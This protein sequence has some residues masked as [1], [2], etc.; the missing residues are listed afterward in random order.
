MKTCYI[1]SF[2]FGDRRRYPKIYNSDRLIFLKKQIEYLNNIENNLDTIIFNF[3]LIENHY[4][5]FNQAIKL[6]PDYINNTK[7]LINIRKNHDFSYG[8]WNEIVKKEVENY[9]HFIFGE[10][11]YVFNIDRWDEYL[12][13]KYESL[14]DC[15]YLGMGVRNVLTKNRERLIEYK[16]YSELKE[17]FH[18][19]GMVSS[20]NI[21]KILKIKENL[22]EIKKLNKYE[23]EVNGD[24]IERTQTKWSCQYYEVGLKNYDI[25]DDYAVEFQLTDRIENIWRLFWWNDKIIIKSLFTI[26][27]PNYTW[28]MTY[29]EDYQLNY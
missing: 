11:D 17:S 23:S 26:L 20:K 12:V 1:I 4:D 6:I 27:Q 3:N 13:K 8:A 21:K 9:T 10:D 16:N 19:I 29:D 25:R 7:V 5:L 2:W 24:R 22:I 15:G 28:Y 18:S 14:K